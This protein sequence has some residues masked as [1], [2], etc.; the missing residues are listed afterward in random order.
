MNTFK[1]FF[2]NYEQTQYIEDVDGWINTI[3]NSNKFL[4]KLSDLL[5]IAQDR[6]GNYTDEEQNNARE[7]F[8]S[9]ANQY[10]LEH[11]L[12]I[13]VGVDDDRD[14]LSSIYQSMEERAESWFYYLN[15]LGLENDVIHSLISDYK[16]D[17]DYYNETISKLA[18]DRFRNS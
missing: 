6:Y 16:Y 3:V 5:D 8:S 18:E 1:I 15:Q 7:K 10:V 12:Q 11:N 9:M 17:K 2:E 14:V 13:D 4:H